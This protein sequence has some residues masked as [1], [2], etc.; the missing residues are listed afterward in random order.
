MKKLCYMLLFFCILVIYQSFAVSNTEEVNKNTPLREIV[1]DTETTG[2]IPEKGYRLVEIGAVEL[3]NHVKTGKTFHKYINPQRD[4]P[5]KAVN[6]H[7][8]NNEFLA[9]KPTFAEIAQEWLDFVGDNSVLV[10]HNANFDMKFLNFELKRAGYKEYEK[11]KF[12]DTLKI[13]REV[14]P[15]QPNDI[16][17][18]CSRLG[19]DNSERE[20]Y[21][22]GALRDTELL[23]DIYIKLLSLKVVNT[24]KYAIK[25]NK[26]LKIKY[27][28]HPN[29][30]NE[31]TVR[32]II[33]QQLEYGSVLMSGDQK[34]SFTLKN[35]ELY[36]NAFCELRNDNRTFLVSRILEIELLD[37]FNPSHHI[38]KSNSKY[39]RLA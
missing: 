11:E 17:A 15:S 23:A 33:P 8:L 27:Q 13:A 19:I 6:I 31:I 39:H 25:N 24:I 29:Y 3:I 38:F 2:L 5:E 21:G 35:D 22:H 14:F 28:S 34:Y 20:K 12:I 10:A 1:F 32:T 4:V 36:L 30:G 26:K 9:D 37:S 7:H 18:L 16:D